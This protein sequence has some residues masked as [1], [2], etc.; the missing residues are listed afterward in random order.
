VVGEIVE[1]I[2]ADK[3][4]H[5]KGFKPYGKLRVTI[6]ELETPDGLTYPLVGSLAPDE[7][8]T[9]NGGRAKVNQNVGNGVAYAGSQAGFNMVAPG[10][11]GRNR[12]GGVM[13]PGDVM[14]NPLYA[15]QQ[16]QQGQ[17][18]EEKIR[19]LVPK[20]HELF[21]YN[22]S[23]LS[24]MVNAPFKIGISH[25]PGADAA[26]QEARERSRSMGKRFER[27]EDDK[28][29]ASASQAAP[30]A[31]QAQ[32]DSNGMGFLQQPLQGANTAPAAQS[33]PLTPPG[34]TAAPAGSVPGMPATNS[35]PS[36]GVPQPQSTPGS[37]F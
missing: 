26:Y 35:T 8:F 4:K 32:D 21:I 34:T 12:R 20:G 19:S 13:A 23:P 9:R 18:G 17:N 25:A 28:P 3:V 10:T 30:A 29:P 27:D 22:G 7:Y 37:T 14:K 31:P 1:A 5:P 6:T 33:G 16:Q 15:R 2:P 24:V 36:P 11:G